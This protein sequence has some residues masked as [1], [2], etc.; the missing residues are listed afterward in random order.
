MHQLKKYI[1]IL[2]VS[3]SPFGVLAQVD[4][5]ESIVIPGSEFKYIVPDSE[6]STD[7]TSLDFNDEDWGDGVSSIG[8]GDDDDATVTASVASVYMRKTFTI[9]DL[10]VIEALLLHMDY[11]DGFVAYLNGQ[12]VARSLMTGIPPAFNQL[13]DG[14]HEAL[15]YQNQVPEKF[16][17]SPSLLVAGENV[18]AVQVHNESLSSSDLTA[19]P[20]LSLGISDQSNN[21]LA[22]PDWF[23]AP[24]NFTSS[25][26]PIVFIDTENNAEIPDEPKIWANMQIV[27]RGEGERTFTADKGDEDYIDFDN[28]IK[29][30]IRGSSSQTLPKKQYGFTTY[31]EEREKDN[32]E[33][34]GMPKENDWILNGLAF[35]QSLMRDYIAYNLSRQIGNYASRTQYC[36]VVLNGSYNG[37]YVLQEKLK[38]DS[39]RIDITAVGDNED[40]VLTGGYITKSDKID[41]SDPVAWSMPNHLG[42]V[43]NFVHEEP[44][45]DEVTTAQNDYI[46]GQFETL[47]ATLDSKNASIMNGYPSVIDIPSF[48]D[49]ML[50]NE[51]AS[52][53]DAYEFSTYF[54][55]DKNGKL[56]AGPIWD[57]N[58]TIGNDLFMYG[59]DRSFTD[60]WQFDNGDNVGAK[61]WKDLFDDNDFRCYL[62][63][64]WN[65]LTQTGMP[66]NHSQLKLFIEETDALIAEALERE[67]Q[68][69][70]TVSDHTTNV[71][72][73]INWLAGRI[74]WMNANIGSF[75]ACE[76]VPTSSLVIS[77]INY[78]PNSEQFGDIDE[79][80][81]I[82]ITN[83]GNTTVNLTGVYF[84]GTGFVYQFPAGTM[85]GA[86]GFVRLA[87]DADTF[88]DLYGHSP[89][90]EFTRK[91]SN[92]GQRLTLL[93]G[94]GNLIDEVAYDDSDPWPEAADGDGFYLQ[95]NDLLAD[96]NN[97]INWSATDVPL[98]GAILSVG[99]GNADDIQIFPN[100]SIDVF[101]INAPTRIQSITILSLQGNTLKEVALN[102]S[103][104]NLD[105]SLF[106]SGTYI[107]K[108]KT[109][110][111]I[112]VRKVIK[113]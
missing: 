29:I 113:G 110:S 106:T 66:F 26:L 107:L 54:H 58:L 97:A 51:L 17:L 96:N 24:L 85:L 71:T 78:N 70:G 13:S 104:Y 44:K 39:D 6:L 10:S 36:E 47:Q 37:L 74:D 87:N 12:E 55:K 18:L 49:F 34:L 109:E 4:H 77:K 16:E 108:V 79:Q 64:R 38:K 50:L 14:L 42:G 23:R 60:I 103:T 3:L 62:A 75:T 25:N 81:F 98:E 61:F 99:D 56:R 53:V 59:L 88:M 11:D 86:G 72:G 102:E 80:E 94:F 63:K 89:F 68:T 92:G 31:D 35:D 95:L 21:Y 9:V 105:L 46:K 84:G 112:L 65:E 20:V 30:E 5:W 73:M 100:P 67:Q 1:I 27:Y 19:L 48:V 83:A 15:L 111:S 40:G 93:D 33:L 43:T 32:V 41:E 90:G 7:W 22:T 82:E 52:N 69:W 28:L 8:Y 45:D 76:N 101:Q 2:L 57:F 91:L